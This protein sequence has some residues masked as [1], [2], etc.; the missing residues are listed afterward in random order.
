MPDVSYP[1]VHIEEVSVPHSIAG[2]ATSVT[3]FVGSTPSGPIDQPTRL[4]SF[5]EFERA[6]DAASATTPLGVGVWL[7]FIN[8]GRCPSIRIAHSWS[9]SYGWIQRNGQAATSDGKR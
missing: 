1:G 4:T 2:V 3:A 9:S 6:F 5:V 7:F 8:G